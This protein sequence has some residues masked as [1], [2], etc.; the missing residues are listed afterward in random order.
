MSTLIL[1]N[2]LSSPV[3]NQFKETMCTRYCHTI[4]CQHF[5]ETKSQS[6]V[7]VKLTE[8]YASNIRWLMD[9]PIGLRY[10]E[11]NLL[12]YLILVP[13]MLFV[14]LWGVFRDY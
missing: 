9:N 12:V 5:I 1:V 6:S 11:M 14:L 2:E 4:R 7:V 13:I 3:S 10:K 8:A